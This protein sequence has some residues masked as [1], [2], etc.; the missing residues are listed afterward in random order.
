MHAKRSDGSSRHTETVFEARELVV[1]CTD[2]MQRGEGFQVVWQ[3]ISRQFS[4]LEQFEAEMHPLNRSIYCI[5]RTVQVEY[6]TV[7]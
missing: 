5:T 3:L 2:G 4:R 7:Q 6:C 1:K